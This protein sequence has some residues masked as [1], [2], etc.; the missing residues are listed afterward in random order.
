ML[1]VLAAPRASLLTAAAARLPDHRRLRYNC[2][3]R[4]ATVKWALLEQL[5]NPPPGFEEPT[6]AH[7]LHP[8]MLLWPV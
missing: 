1:L 2:V 5:R 6:A 3:I 7:F 8:P 4:E